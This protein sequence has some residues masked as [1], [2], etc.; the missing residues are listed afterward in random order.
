MLD[1]L[2]AVPIAVELRELRLML[3]PFLWVEDAVRG[4]PWRAAKSSCTLGISAVQMTDGGRVEPLPPR[5]SG[6]PVS[7]GCWRRS[8]LGECSGMSPI[9]TGRAVRRPSRVS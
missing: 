3:E 8:R 7:L 6:A 5:L 9:E 1:L 2:E 4:L